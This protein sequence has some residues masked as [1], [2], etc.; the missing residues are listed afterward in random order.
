MEPIVAA[1]GLTVG[2]PGRPLAHGIELTVHPGETVAILGPNGAGKTTLLKTLAGMLPPLEGRVIV[3][4]HDTRTT[5][6]R[7]LARIAAYVPQSPRA[8]PR[9]TVLEYILL[10]LKAPGEGLRVAP[11]E[12]AAA[13]WALETVGAESLAPRM[14]RELS[15]GQRQLVEIAR[16]L[17]VRPR[18]V[19]LDEPTSML[20][21]RHAAHVAGL[22][23]EL[24]AKKLAVI[25]VTHDPNLALDVAQHTLLL[26]PGGRPVYG[27]TEELVEPN[28]LSRLYGARLT[29]VTVEGARRIVPAPTRRRRT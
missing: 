1:H 23:E 3:A 26:E 13:Q 5:P 20:D 28:R 9:L 10:A 6:R 7:A 29:A 4:G 24:A 17:A 27:P 16:A 15:G 18:V 11:E 14:L 21:A 25:M 2:Y 12:L 22:V 19:L 8:A